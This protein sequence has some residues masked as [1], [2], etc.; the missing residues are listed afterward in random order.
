MSQIFVTKL[1]LETQSPMAINSGA[2]EEGFDTQLARDANGLPYIP[3]S[4][5]AGVWGHLASNY[6]DRAWRNK[7]FGD[8][9]QAS[10]LVISHGVL[11]NANNKPVT[12]LLTP[13]DIERDIVLNL[14]SQERPHHRERVA[15]NDRGVAKET[16]KFDQILLPK[17]TRF[18][19]I[20]KWSSQK[21][22][23][24]QQ[25]N[26]QE[27]QE[28]LSLWN[29]QKLAF[30]AS[31]R[32][33]LGK[34]KVQAC[35]QQTFDLSDGPQT[36]Q[37]LQKFINKSEIKNN[38]LP[39]LSTAQTKELASLPLQAIDNWRCGSGTTLLNENKNEVNNNQSIALITYSEPQFEWKN[40]QASLSANKPVLC[41]SSI[42]GILAHRIAYHVNRYTQRWA[43]ELADQSHETWEKAPDELAQLFGFASDDKN[44]GQAGKIYIEDAPL[45]GYTSVIRTHNK[46]DRFT[47]G[48]QQGA[49]FSEELLYQP[50]FT[51]KIWIDSNSNLS[52]LLINALTDTICDLQM[53][54]LPMGAGSGRGTSLVMP[55]TNG[56]WVFNVPESDIKKQVEEQQ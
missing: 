5:I 27:W 38:N 32:N 45:S 4:T 47:G 18:S 54:L 10:T 43:E 31:T 53:G 16:G 44:E 14:L 26:N 36:G 17:G 15:I 24:E 56:E 29:D 35:E 23:D 13:Q 22:N 2:K 1:L 12:P 39:T 30:G 49:L 37:A 7:W 34:I 20:L 50:K 9:T 25:L 51:L 28:L 8:T 6:S 40:D 33:G 48:V 21:R 42:K 11:H 55:Q 3:A 19:V 41:A 52:E 46:I